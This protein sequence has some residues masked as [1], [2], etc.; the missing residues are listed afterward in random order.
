MPLEKSALYV[1]KTED[2]C[3]ESAGVTA[4]I[5]IKKGSDRWKEG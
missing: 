3:V 4:A 1:I 5:K 2:S